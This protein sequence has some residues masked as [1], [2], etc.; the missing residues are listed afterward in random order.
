MGWEEIAGPR[1]TSHRA[2]VFITNDA[3]PRFIRSPGGPP[4]CISRARC[5]GDDNRQHD[6]PEATNRGRYRDCTFAG[7]QHPRRIAAWNAAYHRCFTSADN[8]SNSRALSQERVFDRCLPHTPYSHQQCCGP[9]EQTRT[10][11]SKE[12]MISTG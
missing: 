9:S 12:K 10:S 11:K 3:P 8:R 5:S 6:C 4:T 7:K 2:V 1:S